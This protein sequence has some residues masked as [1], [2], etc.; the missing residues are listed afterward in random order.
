M[1]EQPEVPWHR[2]SCA[3]VAHQGREIALLVL[4]VED[5]DQ[6]ADAIALELDSH[7]EGLMARPGFSGEILFVLDDGL[8]PFTGPGAQ[9]VAALTKAFN[10]LVRRHDLRTAEGRPLAI[11]LLPL[12]E[13]DA[14]G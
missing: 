7:A 8:L 2:P 4:T 9:P 10:D 6:A 3:I 11:R 12:S 14:A 5:W 13:W 1:P